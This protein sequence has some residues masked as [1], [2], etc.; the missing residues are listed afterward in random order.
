VS[1][2]YKKKFVYVLVLG[3]VFFLLFSPQEKFPSLKLRI[4]STPQRLVKI[5]FLP[6][7][8]FKKILYYHRTFNEYKKL[9][10]ENGVLKA[11]LIGLEEVLREN[12]RFAKLLGFKRN[13]IYSSV[14][15]N[16]IGRDP[17]N[18]NASM[19]VDKGIQDG[20]LA[21][22]PVVN[23]MGVVGKVAEVSKSTSRVILLNDPQF[24]VAAL[25]Q[26]PREIGLLSGAL[27]G[28][29]RLRYLSSHA[30]IKV[31]DNVI[32]SKLSSS[33]PEG[34]LIGE[35]VAINKRDD[36]TQAEY[37]VKPAVSLSKIEEVLIIQK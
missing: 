5:L 16:V 22:M 31:G 32:T 21:G 35:I 23:A 33:F 36:Y 11:R 27:Q 2:K 28:N 9:T 24:S 17:T 1:G 18:W 13:L 8:E 30:N 25:V 20:I 37:I 29:C 15:A 34:L 4:S 12:T 19:V 3:A 7:R 26:R 10:K 6:F 14:M